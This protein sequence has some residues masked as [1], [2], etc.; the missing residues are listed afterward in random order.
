MT[1]QYYYKKDACSIETE[2]IWLHFNQC[3][4]MLKRKWN[5]IKFMLRWYWFLLWKLIARYICSSVLSQVQ[6][7]DK[8]NNKIY[9]YEHYSHLTYHDYITESELHT[10]RNNKKKFNNCSVFNLYS[11]EKSFFFLK[12]KLVYTILFNTFNI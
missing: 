1:Q 5:T 8:L 10:M 2:K 4:E 12:R 11:M 9:N 3:I 6:N 7:F